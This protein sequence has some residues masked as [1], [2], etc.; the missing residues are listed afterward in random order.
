MKLWN[1]LGLSGFT[2]F[3]AKL[4]GERFICSRQDE[5]Q[6]D[7][8]TSFV[9][10]YQNTSKFAVNWTMKNWKNVLKFIC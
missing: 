9:I 8:F 4:D 2:S 5:L 3:G 1:G 6:R 7:Y 10:L